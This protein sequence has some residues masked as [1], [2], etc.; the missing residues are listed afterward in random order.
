MNG[1]SPIEAGITLHRGR[2]EAGLRPN[3]FGRRQFISGPERRW[4]LDVTALPAAT[5]QTP[6]DVRRSAAKRRRTTTNVH[7]EKGGIM[8][9]HQVGI[10]SLIAINN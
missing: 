2:I 10:T 1:L 4:I 6:S 7:V 9:R 3:R 5:R 8:A